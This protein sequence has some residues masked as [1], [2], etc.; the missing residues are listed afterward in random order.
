MTAV[1]FTTSFLPPTNK[2]IINCNAAKSTTE[3]ETMAMPGP[4]VAKERLHPT[5]SEEEGG[6]DEDEEAHNG[7]SILF[8]RCS[9]ILSKRRV[10]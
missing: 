9:R 10:F 5:Q 8:P 3:A 2:E 7:E 6:S 1:F 4:S